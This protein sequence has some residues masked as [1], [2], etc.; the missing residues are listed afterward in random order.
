MSV[1]VSRNSSVKSNSGRLV[2][3]KLAVTQKFPI[4]SP[5]LWAHSCEKIMPKKQPIVSH[6][7]QD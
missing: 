2:F 7:L 3:F 5:V 1:I 6:K 4:N